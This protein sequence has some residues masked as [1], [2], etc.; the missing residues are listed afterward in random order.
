MQTVLGF[1]ATDGR[2]WGWMDSHLPSGQAS[3]LPRLRP[4]HTCGL[5]QR[6]PGAGPTSGRVWGSRPPCV[7]RPHRGNGVSDEWSLGEHLLLRTAWVTKARK[8]HWLVLF[9]NKLKATKYSTVT[10][11]LSVETQPSFGDRIM[12]ETVNIR[13]HMGKPITSWWIYRTPT[14]KASWSFITGTFKSSYYLNG[15]VNNKISL[16]TFLFI[17]KG[18]AITIW[19]RAHFCTR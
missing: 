15:C 4:P 9:L 19:R 16:L 14:P 8:S 10:L 11:S 7:W 5:S 18:L 17:R 13:L 3:A 6:D 12:N 1:G 2:E